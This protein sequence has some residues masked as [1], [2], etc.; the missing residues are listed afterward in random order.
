MHPKERPCKGSTNNAPTGIPRVNFVVLSTT[1]LRH[2]SRK[3]PAKQSFSVTSS[4]IWWLRH[5]V[6]VYCST[7][8]VRK[9]Q[10]ICRCHYCILNDNYQRVRTLALC[11]VCLPVRPFASHSH[12]V[13]PFSLRKSSIA[14][15]DRQHSF[16]RHC[17]SL[18]F[19]TT[20]HLQRQRRKYLRACLAINRY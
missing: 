12:I 16:S 6:I 13:G 20:R 7:L 5:W 15:V 1:V 11:A 18:I 14:T 2:F 17:Y 9:F 3:H 10:V 4:S 19:I 8:E